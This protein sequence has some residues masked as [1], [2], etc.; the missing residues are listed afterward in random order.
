MSGVN[1]N[2]YLV[3]HELCRYK[4]RLNG[5]ICH[6]K[7]KKNHDESR[8]ECKKWDDWGSCKDDF[9]LNPST[10][11]CN[12]ACKIDKYLDPKSCS[13]EIWLFGKLVLACGDEVLNTTNNSLDDK[14]ATYEKSNCL[15]HIV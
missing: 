14:K 7:Q 4:F 12:K 1:E 6:S 5:N 9:M 11:E 10:C 13:C 3:Q 15:I 8:F 2:K